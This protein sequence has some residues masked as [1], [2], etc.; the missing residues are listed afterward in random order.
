MIK[1]KFLYKDEG[2]VKLILMLESI[3]DENDIETSAASWNFAVS[4]GTKA[5]YLDS[6]QETLSQTGVFKH[7]HS[8]G[9]FKK[10]LFYYRVSYMST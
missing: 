8:K 6:Y 9:I 3:P 4:N 2:R 5:K 7:H 1:H 10:K